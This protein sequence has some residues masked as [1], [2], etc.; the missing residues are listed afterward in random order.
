MSE[1]IRVSNWDARG[2]VAVFIESPDKE[3]TRTH[4]YVK[5]IKKTCS[6]REPVDP[7]RWRRN[8]MPCGRRRKSLDSF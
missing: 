7:V 8:A 6:T 2:S 5:T 1:Y 4:L 3:G